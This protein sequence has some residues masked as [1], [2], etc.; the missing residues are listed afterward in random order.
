VYD[1]RRGVIAQRS[2][3]RSV[4][5]AVRDPVERSASGRPA[6]RGRA[7]VIL[8]V[9]LACVVVFPI[10]ALAHPAEFE[11]I[12]ILTQRIESQPLNPSLYIDR[13]ASRSHDGEYALAMKDLEKAAELGGPL[14]AA[15][16]LGLL[17]IRMGDRDK[18]RI[19]FDQFIEHFP[20]HARARERRARLLAEI[21]ETDAAAT[22]YERVFA[23]TARPNPGS[24]LSAA[25]MF[26]PKTGGDLT[27]ALAMLDRGI[28]RLGVIPQLQ[29][30]AIELE[31]RRGEDDRAI[32]RLEAL[33]S[34]LGEG[35][36]WNIQMAELLIR[37]EKISQAQRHLSTAK[38]ALRDLRQTPARTKLSSRIA[39]IEATLVRQR[40]DSI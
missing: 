16:E 13:A 3:F 15:Y 1:V 26:A 20:N 21:G 11:R 18:A 27:L 29:Q 17:H 31:V 6:W 10:P 34:A 40:G 38:N 32:E 14:S 37:T 28:Q 35:P 39:A 5:C 25:K 2:L 23:V 24:Y 33:K 22:D 8:L 19:Q 7:Q 4:L 9:C 36:E 12:E 30:Y